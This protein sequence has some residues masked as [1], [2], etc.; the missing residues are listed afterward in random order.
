MSTLIIR[1]AA[2][3]QNYHATWSAMK[4]FTD[5]RSLKTLDELWFVEHEPI[6]T[7]GLVGNPEHVLNSHGIPIVQTDRGGQITYHAPGQLVIYVLFNLTE[8]KLDMRS[9]VCKLEQ[10][11][12]DYLESLGMH[13][14]ARAD[15]PGVYI[16]G[17]KICSIGLRIRKNNS[18]HGLALNVDMDLKPF[19]YI[20]PC[21]FKGLQMTQIKNYAAAIS[22]VEVKKNIIPYFAKHFGYTNIVVHENKV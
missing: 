4:Q 10:T 22:M 12:M 21:G 18:Y 19:S 13:A 15:A 20:N 9:L 7:Q 1:Q 14:F 5:H 11:I 3:A 17:D 6:F 2:T 8:L 16:E